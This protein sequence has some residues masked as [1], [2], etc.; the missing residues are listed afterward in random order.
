MNA[1]KIIVSCIIAG[2]AVFSSHG[3]TITAASD[4]FT[5]P[6]ITSIK[7]MGK[8]NLPSSFSCLNASI[9]STGV[10]F[11]WSFPIQPQ[12]LKGAITVYSPQGRRLKRITLSDNAGAVAW[13]EANHSAMGV[14]IA[15]LTYGTTQQTL[16]FFIGK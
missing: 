5:F 2:F 9:K 7:S 16:K 1:Y 3:Q 10:Q 6:A 14:Y 15:K 12:H 4:P 13:N 11:L 8:I